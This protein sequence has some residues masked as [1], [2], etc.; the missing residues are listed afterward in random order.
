[1]QPDRSTRRGA[2]RAAKLLA[3]LGS[4]VLALLLAEGAIRALG[5]APAVKALEI[6][7]ADSVYRRSTN[8]ILGFELKS[9]YRNPD[10]DFARSYPSTNSWGQRDVE[11]TV[12]AR[13]GGRRVLLLGD[14]VVE[15]HDIRDLDDTISRRLERNSAGDVEVL[16]FGVSGYCTR[17][18]VELL[19]VKG[20]A[21]RPDV[22]L[23]VFVANDFDDFNREAYR[24]E[25]DLARPA[26]AERLFHA[27][28]LFRAGSIRTNLFGFG[29]EFDPVRWNRRAIGEGN[30]SEGLALLREL[31]EAHGFEVGVAVW[32]VFEDDGIVDPE[33]MPGSDALIV[34]RLAAMHGLSVR[35]LAPAFR[36][37]LA[38]RG[39]NASPRLL[40]TVGDRLH[41]SVE[42]CR[43]A[44][45]ALRAWLAE[46]GGMALGPRSSEDAEAIRAS[47][48]RGQSAPDYA[49]VF[50]NEG[51]THKR[52]GR[53]DDAER[54]FHRALAERPDYSDAH[55]NLANL[56]LARGDLEG[57]IEHYRSAL[58]DPGAGAEVQ[59]NLAIA[60]ERSGDLGA[61]LPHYESAAA[62][63]PGDPA[64][65]ARLGALLAQAGRLDEAE[66][67]F[68]R[69]VE[70]DAAAAGAHHGLGNVFAARGRLD[71]A[72]EHY[73]AAA[74]LRPDWSAPRRAL[75]RISRSTRRAQDGAGAGG[76]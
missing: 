64:L 20:L 74:E 43:V 59:R 29:A 68:R 63:I 10:A 42:G 72:A 19:R 70:L 50:N 71:E 18:E 40:Y 11:R 62:S 31:A 17:A 53:E 2:G 12:E 21:F 60:L 30:V 16:N 36:A 65:Q 39:S 25:G 38:R 27:S 67:A 55:N 49:H 41:P 47:L 58:E 51:L 14:S 24:L 33:A 28:H 76:S 61:A 66:A 8:P 54:S 22:V 34:E 45:D 6:D 37:D 52:A 35:R 56:L 15:G 13:P 57:A 4:T 32:P 23:L 3:A 75:E 48:D 1:M 69:A 44:A 9:D 5:V 7:G 73:R 46:P 26:W